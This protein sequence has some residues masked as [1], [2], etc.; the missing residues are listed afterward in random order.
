MG[1]MRSMKREQKVNTAK[2]LKTVVEAFQEGFEKG[3]KEGYYIGAEFTTNLFFD[4]LETIQSVKGIGPKRY[5]AIL[6]HFDHLQKTDL[7]GKKS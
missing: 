1:Q 4:A 2:R 3:R 5:H 7:R 6:K